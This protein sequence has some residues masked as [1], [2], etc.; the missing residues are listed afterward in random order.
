M[1]GLPAVA[2]VALMLLLTFLCA[3]HWGLAFGWVRWFAEKNHWPVGW[4]LGPVWMASEWLRNYTLTGLPWASLGYSQAKDLWLSQLASLGGVYGLALLVA[5]VNGALYEAWRWRFARERSLPKLELGLAAA[6]LVAGLTYGALRVRAWDEKIARA[7]RLE[8]AVVQG[9]VDEK[10]KLA[11]PAFAPV[12]LDAYNAP[13]AQA[14]DAG[15]QLIVWPESS[16]PDAFKHGE[17]WSLAHR[18]LDRARYRAHLLVGVDVYDP[19]DGRSENAAFLVAPDLEVALEY[20]KH[21]LVLL[22]E[23]VPAYL[24]SWLPIRNLVPGRFK[25]GDTLA[26]AR[27]GEASVGIEICFDAVFPEIS[28]ALARQHAQLLVNMTNDAWWGFSGAPFQFL[29]IVELRAIETGR[30][31]VRA[32]NTGVSGFIDPVGRMSQLTPLGLVET[33]DEHADLGLK[34]PPQWRMAAVPLMSED[35]VYV[36]LGDLPAYVAVLFCAVGAAVAWRRSRR[37]GAV[38]RGS[39]GI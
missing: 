35:T 29:R 5:F 31:V 7:P 36:V 8:V 33:E 20:V 15:A 24:D 18:G 13:T 6:L 4:T 27:V 38:P 2:G 26:P 30:P 1:P 37:V 23:Y 12:I 32:A 25:P 16:F 10:L 14:D 3:L 22:G 28:R 9:N 39:L 11:G 19:A 21:H 34:I 17:H